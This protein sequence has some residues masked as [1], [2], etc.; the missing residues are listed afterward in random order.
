MD[1]PGPEK[2]T[3]LLVPWIVAVLKA[4]VGVVAVDVKGYV[5]MEIRRQVAA[6]GRQKLGVPLYR[7][8][9]ADVAGSRS[10]NP[11]D[12]VT[13]SQSL[14]ALVTALLGEIDAEGRD[15]YFAERH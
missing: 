3:R 5:I 12:E 6:S 11:L 1:L 7:W 10:W 2:T 14:T 13:D 8:D 4:G 9:I 15:R